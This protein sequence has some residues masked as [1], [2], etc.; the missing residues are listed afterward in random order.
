MIRFFVR[1]IPLLIW[2]GIVIGYFYLSDK[3][4]FSFAA[5]LK[6]EV[7]KS[8]I[9]ILV[10]VSAILFGVIG[11]WLALIYPTA[12]QRIQGGDTVGL[13]YSG[14]DL[15]V[16]KGLVLV[17]FFS[18][19]TLIFSM[20]TELCLTLSSNPLLNEYLSYGDVVAVCALF[21]WFLFFVQM[22]AILSLLKSS[23]KL[24]YDLFL[25][26]AFSDLNNLLRRQ[27]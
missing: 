15:D 27:K 1:T 18:S 2:V 26:K 19:L 14:V 17:L 16:L 25:S 3:Y 5:T 21:V 9:G 24:V 11:A 7:I 10:N 13:A 20:F 12:L 8:Q 22:V 23:F 4:L 6:V